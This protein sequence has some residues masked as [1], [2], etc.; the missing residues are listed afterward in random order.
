M[1][2]T[3][4][5][6]F[7]DILLPSSLRSIIFSIFLLYIKNRIAR[8]KFHT[9]QFNTFFNN[10][11]TFMERVVFFEIF[12]YFCRKISENKKKVLYR[13]EN[14]FLFLPVILCFVQICEI[15]WTSQNICVLLLFVLRFYFIFYFLLFI[16]W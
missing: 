16:I 4:L 8:A 15:L 9:Q 13:V 14:W 5:G 6:H 2:W 7:S 3:V 10:L 1:Y 11:P 12:I